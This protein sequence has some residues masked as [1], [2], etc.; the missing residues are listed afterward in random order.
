[1]PALAIEAAQLRPDRCLRLFLEG[2]NALAV[3]LRAVR[4]V[5][6]GETIP[7]EAAETAAVLKRHL[8]AV[9]L[10]QLGVI[11]R[12]LPG[13]DLQPLASSWLRAADLTAARAALA[14]TGDLERTMRAVCARAADPRRAREAAIELAW[15]SVTDE[16]WKVRS[17]VA[18]AQEARRLAV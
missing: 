17:R 12:H 2:G 4:A 14:L 18:P 15:S 9:A 6:L 7:P 11:A 10:D 5:A 13:G 1:V 16:I 3:V 8:Q